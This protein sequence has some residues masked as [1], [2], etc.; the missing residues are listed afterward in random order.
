MNFDMN[1]MS[2]FPVAFGAIRLGI[3]GRMPL[4]RR[5][6]TFRVGWV[7]TAGLYKRKTGWEW[8]FMTNK[9]AVRSVEEKKNEAT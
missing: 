7:F 4:R 1:Q 6:G 2:N 3:V 8:T 5:R 9:H